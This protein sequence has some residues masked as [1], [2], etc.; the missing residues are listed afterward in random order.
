MYMIGPYIPMDV[1]ETSMM[2]IVKVLFLKK[3]SGKT[4]STA[5]SSARRKRQKNTTDQIMRSMVGRLSV[6]E[7]VFVSNIPIKQR[8]KAA[9]EKA[10]KK[11]ILLL[12]SGFLLR[13]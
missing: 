4:G 9:M 1:S 13:K 10:P 8:I 7:R 3:R 5:R 11:S 6:N 12:I 2:T